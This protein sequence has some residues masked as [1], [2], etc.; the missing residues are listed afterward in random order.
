MDRAALDA[1]I[2]RGVQHGGFCPGGRRA[3]DGPIPARYHLT[4][5]ITRQYMPRTVMNVKAADATLVLSWGKPTGG[6]RQTLL[7]LETHQKPFRL[8]DLDATLARDPEDFAV[9]FVET[10]GSR[11]DSAVLNV[12]GPRAS[13][14]PWVYSTAKKFVGTV[15]DALV[16]R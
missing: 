14:H 8:Y 2:E 6:T 9:W 12:A 7:V 3:E 5:L 10:I 13:K 16:D 1:A 15:L 4:E 11:R